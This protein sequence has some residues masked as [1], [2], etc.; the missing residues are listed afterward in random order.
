MFGLKTEI[1]SHGFVIYF[2]I[3]DGAM[4]DLFHY[5]HIFK[6]N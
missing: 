6:L 1:P 4:I 3:D 5:S 2:L